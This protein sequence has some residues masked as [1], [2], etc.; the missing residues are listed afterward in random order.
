MPPTASGATIT[1]RKIFKSSYP[2]FVEIKIN[3]SGAGTYDIRQLSDDPSPQ[4]MEVD[5][6]VA[7][8][9]FAL[10][11][12]LH[13]FDGINLEMHRRIANLGQKTFQ[14]QLGAVK[15]AV[16]FNYT[17]DSNANQLLDVFEGLARQQS[18]L[19]DLRRAMRYDRLG[20]N[21]VL[22]QVQK[23]YDRNLLI[24]PQKFLASLDQLA[25]D[26]HFINIAREKAHD[27]AARI[28][29]AR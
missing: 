26:D 3:E 29:S 27:L 14:Y 20:V 11:A 23:D 22:L 5:P 8:K 13:D 24:E 18:D 9:I 28:R 21:D 19:S 1:F 12:K 7:Q 15:H 4:P 10:A 17:Q 16:T 6:A 2:E 25:A